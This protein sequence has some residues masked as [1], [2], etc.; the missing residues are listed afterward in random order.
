MRLLAVGGATLTIAGIDMVDGTP[1]LD[2]K[3]YIPP[4]DSHPTDQIGWFAENVARVGQAAPLGAS[5]EAS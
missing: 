5:R 1:P 2:I 3:H 4:F